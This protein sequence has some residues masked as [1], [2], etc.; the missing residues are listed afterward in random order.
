ETPCDA[1][2]PVSHRLNH[3]FSVYTPNWGFGPTSRGSEPAPARRL[4]AGPRRLCAP[5][6]LREERAA[7]SSPRREH[8]A[9]SEPRDQTGDQ[10]TEEQIDDRG[11]TPTG[12]DVRR[13]D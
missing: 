6:A 4:C 10:R 11:E 5:V 9:G 2:Y 12:G 8:S 3:G 1:G 7:R 13:G